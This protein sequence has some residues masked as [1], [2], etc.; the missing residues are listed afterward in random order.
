MERSE[1][2][3]WG[4]GSSAAATWLTWGAEDEAQASM[5][6]RLFSRGNVPRVFRPDSGPALQWGRGSSA[7]ATQ[8][9]SPAA[10]STLLQWGRGSSAAATTRGQTH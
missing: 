9:T 1:P 2:L 3:Q 7:A 8:D 5:G 6:P 4:R 10:V